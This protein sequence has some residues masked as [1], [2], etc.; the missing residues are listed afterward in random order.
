MGG[1]GIRR[2]HSLAYI[3][4][5]MAWGFDKEFI[6]KDAGISVQSLDRRLSR[7]GDREQDEYQ[8]DEFEA[9]CD[10][11]DCRCSEGSKG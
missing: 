10:K 6:A 3:R 4:Q 1:K 9:G 11:C 2:P 7:A 8:G 5:M